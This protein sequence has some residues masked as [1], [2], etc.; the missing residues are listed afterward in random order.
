MIETLRRR[1]LIR[2]G[3]QLARELGMPF[4]EPVPGER[5][6]GTYR[7]HV[8]ALSGRYALIERSREFTLLPWRP[9]LER[10]VGKNVS[11]IARRDGISWT[12][13]RERSG[14]ALS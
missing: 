5:V 11:G 2:I 10:H 3:D 4:V 1:E 13:G 9:V 7:R 8:E 6:S 14:P 12:I